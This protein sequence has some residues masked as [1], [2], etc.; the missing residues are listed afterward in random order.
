LKAADLPRK[1]K[2]SGRDATVDG[3]YLKLRQ[4]ILERKG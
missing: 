2:V 1:V 4:A 3:M